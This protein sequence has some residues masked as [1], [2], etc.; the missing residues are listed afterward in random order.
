MMMKAL[1][2]LAAL[3]IFEIVREHYNFRVSRYE[4]CQEK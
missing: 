4:I 2:L 1:A 3:S